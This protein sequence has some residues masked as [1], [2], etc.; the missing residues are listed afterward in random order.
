MIGQ[1]QKTNNACVR[2]GICFAGGSGVT[3]GNS[4]ELES[5]DI[6]EVFSVSL[7]DFISLLKP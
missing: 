2:L 5:D 7:M 3:A 6:E 4:G 1:L